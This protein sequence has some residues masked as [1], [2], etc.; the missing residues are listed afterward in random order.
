MKCLVLQS[1]AG[2]Q[3]SAARGTEINLPADEAKSLEHAGIV[4]ILA[5]YKPEMAYETAQ[6]SKPENKA[7]SGKAKNRTRH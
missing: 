1:F 6:L 3:Y 5:D 2:L 4:K 7:I